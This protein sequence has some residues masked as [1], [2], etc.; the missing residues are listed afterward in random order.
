MKEFRALRYLDGARFFYEKMGVNYPMMRKILQ[1]KMTLD[2]RRRPTIMMKEENK[3]EEKNLFRKSLWMYG[4]MGLVVM[5]FLFPNYSLFFKMNMI[6]GMLVF[7]V[8]TIMISDFSSVLLDTKEKGILLTRPIDVRTI[9]AAKVT[10]IL[11]YL[12]TITM[13][14]ATPTLIVGSMKYGLIFPG[15]LLIQLL[16]I[17]GLILLFTSLLYFLILSFFSGEKLKDI[18]NYFQIFLTIFMIIVYQLIGN[19][20][21]VLD[22]NITFTPKWW[23]YFIPSTWFAAPFSLILEGQNEAYYLVSTM[24]GIIVPLLIAILYFKKVAPFFE[25]KLQ[26]LNE[27]SSKINRALERRE[28]LQERIARVLC[29]DPMERVFFRFAKNILAHE[30]NLKLKLYPNLALAAI[31]PLIFLVRSFSH[32][33]SLE[34]ML[35]AVSGGKYYLII[36]LSI[37]LLVTNLPMLSTG[38]GYRAAWI[39]KVLPVEDFSVIYKGA[40]KAFIVKLILPLYIFMATIFLLLYGFEIMGD[41]LLMFF[42]LVFAILLIF[43]CFVKSLPF[44]QSFEEVKYNNVAAVFLAGGF[45]A[46]SAY[47]HHLVS[48]SNIGLAIYFLLL[49]LAIIFLWKRSMKI[50]KVL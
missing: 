26:K 28:R 19:V 37:A 16:V 44:S 48:T 8:M 27:N 21:Q 41:I 1:V 46:V 31:M 33:N 18:I 3:E 14:I 50:K 40:L 17:P 39:Y 32:V 43:Y 4:M 6:Y 7:M 49:L 24:M 13:I 12:L 10:H 35:E 15:I 42:N 36:Y 23:S 22:Y 45:C 29:W 9:N 5:I 25:E 30:R 47:I 34:E 38:E 20:F 11:M 2:E